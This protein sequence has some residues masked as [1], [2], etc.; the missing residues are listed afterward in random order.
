MKNFSLA[1]VLVTVSV[2]NVYCQPTVSITFDDGITGDMPGYPFEQW[3][4]MLLDHL[5]SANVKAIFFVTGSNKVDEKGQYLLKTWNDRGHKLANH[6]FTHPNYNSKDITF[7][8]FKN[9]FIQTDAVINK[10]E[11]HIRL[12]RFPYLKEGDSETKVTQFRALLKTHKY[13]NGYVTIDASDWYVDSRL[14]KRLKENPKA[15]IDS[16]RQ[17]YLEHLLNRA[18]YYEELAFK[19]TGR[20]IKHTL[21]LHHNLASALF[22]GDLITRFKKQGWNVI[23]AEEAY[24][25][26]IFLANPSTI[27]AGESLIWA[28]AKESGK[29]ESVL[30]YPAEDG[31]YE[32]EKMDKLGL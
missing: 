6:T 32:K 13:R 2:L 26:K 11:N 18:M 17:F 5:D 27:P 24:E 1:I 8:R 30:R 19:L 3:N 23:S 15:E 25:D 28:L 14:R 9:E 7:N 22:L 31:I 20:H 21:L 16:F 12:F 29:F 4:Q 10:F